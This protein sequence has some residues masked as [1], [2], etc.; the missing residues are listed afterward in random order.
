M[1]IFCLLTFS[2]IGQENPTTPAPFI[3]H[4][5]G[6]V[7]A[8][9]NGISLIPSFSLGRPAVFFDLSVGGERLSFDPMFR[10]G[11]NGKP[12]SFIFWWRYK[13]IKDKKFTFSAGAHP[14]FI[15]TEKD[16]IVDG[17]TEKMLVAQ[18]F[19]AMELAPNYRISPKTT[20]GLYFLKGHGLNPIPPNNTNFIS[21]NTVFN[22]LPL[23]NDFRIRI[24]PQFYYLK[25]DEKDGTYVTS[26]FA[27]TNK[28]FPISIQSIFNQKIKS[29]IAGEELVWNVSLV[30]SFANK[31]QKQ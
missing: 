7:T 27:I 30:Y 14:A 8:T 31:Y 16:V 1:A 12:W 5:N 18:R 3:K 25:V 19:I 15:F 20:I 13:V 4:F 6:T 22:D 28:K 26:S 17:K 23:I 9:N 21:F 11:M 2:A 10:F 29:D 24:N